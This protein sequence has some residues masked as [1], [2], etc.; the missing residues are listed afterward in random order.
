MDRWLCIAEI[1]E[2]LWR[3]FVE[4]RLTREV[5]HLLYVLS[6]TVLIINI[7]SGAVVPCRGDFLQFRMLMKTIAKR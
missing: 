1:S 3:G 5:L 2:C 4:P 7:V 6:K